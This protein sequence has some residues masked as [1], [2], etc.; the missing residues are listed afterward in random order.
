[1]MAQLTPLPRPG[2]CWKSEAMGC[3]LGG[4]DATIDAWSVDLPARVP[5]P[6]RPADATEGR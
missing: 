2:R 6:P 4:T 5:S 1:M 3:A